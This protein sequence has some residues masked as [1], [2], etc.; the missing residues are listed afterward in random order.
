MPLRH[1]GVLLAIACIASTL[2]RG[3]DEDGLPAPAHSIRIGTVSLSSSLRLR[4]EGWNSFLRDSR[5]IYG[6]GD[7]LLR[8]GIA[9]RRSGF[10]WKLE[11]GQS[12]L[13]SLPSNA[14]FP[15]T[16]EPLGLGATYFAANDGER[17][18]AAV[19]LKQAYISFKGFGENGSH[20]RVGRFVFG[21]GMELAPPDQILAAL[22]RDRLAYRLIGDANWT[23][24]G[25]SFDGVKLSYDRGL[26]NITF[27]AARPTEGVYQADALRQLDVDVLY[28]AYTREF[29]TSIVTSELRLFAAGYHDGR[30][31]LKTDNRPL[32]EREQDTRNIR[33]GTFGGH[34]MS[35]WGTPIGKWDALLW[36]AFQTGRWGVLD[37]RAGSVDVELGWHPPLPWGKPWLRA[38]A[39]RGSGD[40]RP[41]DGTHETFFQMLPTSQWY[42]RIPFYTFQNTMD[43]TGQLILQLHK[44]VKLESQIHKVKLTEKK[45]L[46]YLG[47]G[48]FQNSSFG[49]EAIS[50]GGHGGLANYLDMSVQYQ[51]SS[52]LQT[53]FYVGALSGKAAMT[54]RM[55]GRKGG[56]A[57][58]ELLYYF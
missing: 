26:W 35:A 16:R 24:V 10:D 2:A 9:Q 54:N 7:S 44:R 3:A 18:V 20:F 22:K 1:F 45:D 43:F 31:V 12:T 28:A 6:Y 4:G 40:N 41:E 53:T 49:Y 14:F 50:G 23:A 47:T 48:A 37:H 36:G 32:A 15:D 29:S 42:A 17:N 38:S 33:I 39:F 25:R 57:Y 55:Q 46:W 27:L 30:A 5:A 34:F 8:L 21:D 13:F 19:F 56:Y 52:H 11:L 51:A 58:I